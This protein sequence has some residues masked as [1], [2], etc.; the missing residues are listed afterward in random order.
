MKVDLPLPIAGGFHDFG[1]RVP[2]DGNGDDSGE[3]ERKR[4]RQTVVHVN[5]AFLLAASRQY[6]P[7]YRQRSSQEGEERFYC[8]F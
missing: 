3:E 1:N 5:S 7:V 8:Q 4:H 6:P 2:E